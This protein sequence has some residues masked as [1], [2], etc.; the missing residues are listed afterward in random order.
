[1]R[2]EK[3]PVEVGISGEMRGD[4]G[5]YGEMHVPSPKRRARSIE[6]TLLCTIICAPPASAAE[7]VYEMGR[8]MRAIGGSAS[9]RRL[10]RVQT[11]Y[12]VNAPTASVILEMK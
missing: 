12:N 8:R 9:P 2:G 3:R 1:M 7:T 10:R 4:V 11:V 6:R 5:R